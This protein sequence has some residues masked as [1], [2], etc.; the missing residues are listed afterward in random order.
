MVGG[1]Q[2]LFIQLLNSGLGEYTIR[3]KKLN[4]AHRMDT[5]LQLCEF[6]LFLDCRSHCN[7]H[8]WGNE[9]RTSFS[10]SVTLSETICVWVERDE[11]ISRKMPNN[12]LRKEKHYKIL[13]NID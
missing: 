2:K 1:D 6:A 9:L 11:I 4:N 10:C 3:I 7:V 13:L 8:N 12:S 5:R